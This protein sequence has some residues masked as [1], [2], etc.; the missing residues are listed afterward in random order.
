VLIETPR[1]DI[2]THII[3]DVTAKGGRFVEI[4]G[5]D[6]IMV[7]LTLPRIVAYNGPGVVISRFG[8]DGFDGERLLVSVKTADLGA[9]LKAYPI[10]EGGV[11]HI[12]DY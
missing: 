9:I 8:R 5:N 12:F 7:S 3:A 1:Y 10:G 11:E 2:F 4:A 6:D